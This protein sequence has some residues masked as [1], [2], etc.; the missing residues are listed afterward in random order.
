M[1]INVSIEAVASSY[2]IQKKDIIPLLDTLM[3]GILYSK[4]DEN[5]TNE[6]ISRVLNLL[7][8]LSRD[9][10]GAEAIA[11][12]KNLTLRLVLY[13]NRAAFPN[14]YFLQC[15][16]VLNNVFKTVADFRSTYLDKHG[17]TLHSLDRCV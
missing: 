15:L 2:L 17:F 14:E 4:T 9:V 6:V 16:R 13:F 5:G 10:S 11:V 1:L 8:K 12:S 3:T 7:A